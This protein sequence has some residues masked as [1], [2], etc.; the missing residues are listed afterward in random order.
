MFR[1]T[2]IHI[3]VKTKSGIKNEKDF[4]FRAPFADDFIFI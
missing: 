1:L 2:F 3:F 4:S